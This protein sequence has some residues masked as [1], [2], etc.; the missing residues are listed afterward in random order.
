MMKRHNGA[1]T[2]RADWKPPPGY[3]SAKGKAY[4]KWKESRPKVNALDG[5]NSEDDSDS[6]GETAFMIAAVT[7]NTGH[8]DIPNLTD[9]ESEFGDERNPEH[10]NDGMFK[11]SGFVKEKPTYCSKV[12]SSLN[13]CKLV[14]AVEYPNVEVVT[15]LGKWAHR[16]VVGKGSQRS[17]KTNQVLSSAQDL[18]NFLKSNPNTAKL[19]EEKKRLSKVMKV[20]T[21]KVK[22]E[23]GEVLVLMDSGSTI[24]VAKIKE[25]FSAYSHMIVPSSGSL[26]GETATTACGKLLRNNGKCTIHGTLD[27]QNITVPFQDMDVQLPIISVRKCVKS[28]KDVRFFP[29]GGELKDR[30]TGKTIK[31]YEIDGTYFIKLK[32]DPPDNEPPS[33]TPFQRLGR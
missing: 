8:D 15:E 20:L 3:V 14:T 11:S 5:M 22:L 12:M 16:L 13:P 10:T 1:S 2:P 9:S 32:V 29:G 33:P 24:D 4:A 19:P 31:I 28:G 7:R 26:S 6:D 17:R 23:D 18:D 30:Q 21:S 27:N 25:H